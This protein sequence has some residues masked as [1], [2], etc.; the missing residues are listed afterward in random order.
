MLTVPTISI[1][2]TILVI[3]SAN[4]AHIYRTLSGRFSSSTIINNT[5]RL[6]FFESMLLCKR[7]FEKKK[8]RKESQKST[9][10][11]VSRLRGGFRLGLR[12]PSGRRGLSLAAELTIQREPFPFSG[13]GQVWEGGL[14]QELPSGETS[15]LTS[16]YSARM[17]SRENWSSAEQVTHD[18]LLLLAYTVPSD[19][20]GHCSL[21]HVD[22]VGYHEQG[23]A[24]TRRPVLST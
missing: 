3:Y 9:R 19:P 13:Y 14:P 8:K 18:T 21:I 17:H 1:S 6:R 10:S 16:N 11:P 15:R 12:G 5:I 20:T 7:L 22:G 24:M 2:A 4:Y 23:K